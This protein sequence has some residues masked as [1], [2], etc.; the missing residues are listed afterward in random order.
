MKRPALI[1]LLVVGVGAGPSAVG[2]L[3]VLTGGVRRILTTGVRRRTI[4][5]PRG[6]SWSNHRCTCSRHRHL[7][8][9]PR[10]TGITAP[11]PQG[12]THRSKAVLSH[13]FGSRRGIRDRE[14]GR[15]T[16]RR[17]S[18]TVGLRDGAYRA[19]RLGTTGH[20]E[21]LRAIPGR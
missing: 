5:R 9:R 13:G 20:R 1:W 7:L 10:P 19:E 16:D 11:A 12:I 14:K 6:L 3:V 15:S 4:T 8:R 18:S 2:A 17:L 21:E